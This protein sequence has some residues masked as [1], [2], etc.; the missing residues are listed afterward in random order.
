[1]KFWLF[2]FAAFE[3]GWLACV[4]GAANNMPW[5]GPVAV[6]I[7][8]ALH[9]KMSANPGPETRLIIL[10]VVMGLVFDSL[11]VTSGWLTYPN[12]M[13]VPGFAP[14]W[15]LAMWA[16]FAT[17]LNVSMSWI[18][19]NL[20]FAAVMGAI[21]GPLSYLAG[22]RLGGLQFVDDTASIVALAIIWAIAMP[23]L[24]IA[25]RRH[26]GFSKL[27]AALPLQNLTRG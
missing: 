24:V 2:N 17:T 27:Q 15:I 7:L 21:F 25:A 3:A 19:A 23:L 20:A 1:M 5:L 12:G 26:D 18:K 13:L 9:L 6:A 14:Y 16:L 10:A 22:Q 4:L 11:L 8:V